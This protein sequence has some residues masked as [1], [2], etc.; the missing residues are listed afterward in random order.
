[1]F[2]FALVSCDKN[3]EIVNT[4][5]TAT[6][7]GVFA[8][9]EYNLDLRDFAFAIKEAINNNQSFRKMIHEE[10][11]K[12]IDGDFDVVISKIASKKLVVTSKNSSNKIGSEIT[13]KALLDETF[14]AIQNRYSNNENCPI[15]FSPQRIKAI[16]SNESVIDELIGKYPNLQIS[17]PVH[18]DDLE[19]ENYIA[20]IA[21]IPEEINEQTTQSLPVIINNEIST[22]SAQ[23]EPANAV[24]VVGMNERSESNTFEVL[25]D[26]PQTPLNLSASSTSSGILLTWQKPSDSSNI[27]GYNIYRKSS[28]DLTFIKIGVNTGSNNVS[29]SDNNILYSSTYTYY[30]TSCNNTFES[31]PTTAIVAKTL[32]LQNP[33]NLKIYTANTAKSLDIEWDPT[34]IGESYEI[35][36]RKSG[37]ADY[38]KI[39]ENKGLYN[40]AY[41]D[42]NLESGKIY[43]YKIRSKNS[44][45]SYS[46]WS[47]NIS[48][49]ASNRQL[50]D[51]LKVLSIMFTD[52]GKYEPWY[53]GDP[54]LLLVVAGSTGS[55]SAT[56]LYDSG[57]IQTSHV[58]NNKWFN[59]N[60]QVTAHWNPNINGSVLTFS[61]SEMDSGSKTTYTLYANYEDKGDNSTIKAGGEVK[62]E[63]NDGN[64]S[65]VTTL[66]NWWDENN[67][68]YKAPYMQW[69]LN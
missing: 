33:K 9:T 64:E 58:S 23:T 69:K 67:T 34:T 68:I 47:S 62:Y 48:S 66:I 57:L 16:K 21:F 38:S 41:T 10:A 17:V 45:D 59:V 20:P 32:D 42:T 44:S 36:R 7:S 14:N 50:N 65:I 37:E 55:N 25:S 53:R 19:N 13:V 61:W 35:W 31:E 40:N 60:L 46:T 3:E 26:T 22:I 4:K 6:Q 30:I 24:I 12:R 29:Y 28:S 18:I 43:S 49:H 39:G 5:N 8:N 63:S 51:E 52:K 27:T 54:E 56:K 1:M 15:K 2:I 11:N